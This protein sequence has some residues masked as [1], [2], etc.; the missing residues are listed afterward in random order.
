MYSVQW[1]LFYLAGSDGAI[2]FL[3]E[4]EDTTV[5]VGEIAQ[6][7]CDYTGTKD[8][9]HWIINGQDYNQSAVYNYLLLM[10]DKDGYTLQ[11]LD[12]E[13]WMDGTTVSCYLLVDGEEIS[14]SIGILHVLSEGY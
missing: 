6:F 1:L 10:K 9:P 3:N 8:E 5:T 12:V 2:S 13:P 7:P 14:S 4:P 11:F